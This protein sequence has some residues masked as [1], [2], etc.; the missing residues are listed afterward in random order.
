MSVLDGVE[1]PEN[2]EDIADLIDD[3]KYEGLTMLRELQEFK[4]DFE[5]GEDINQD[6]KINLQFAYN[7]NKMQ[8]DKLRRLRDKHLKQE[9]SE[10]RSHKAAQKKLNHE[11]TTANSK[12]K[13][14]SRISRHLSKVEIEE[15]CLKRTI[16]KHLDESLYLVVVREAELMA[17]QEFR[18]QG[19]EI[20]GRTI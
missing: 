13:K 19:L 17:N 6:R 2:S 4:A 9:Q 3:I 12:A 11:K 5:A 1:V 16:K 18:D 20:K 10:R 8:V 15:V 14:S 7:K